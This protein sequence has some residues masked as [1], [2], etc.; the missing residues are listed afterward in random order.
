MRDDLDHEIGEYV[1]A[2]IGVDEAA[3]RAVVSRILRSGLGMDAV[4]DRLI[5]AALEL[6]GAR[7][8]SGEISVAQEHVATEI[9]DRIVS[10][11]AA[12]AETPHKPVGTALVACAEGEWHSLAARA[13]H[14]C[15]LSAG[16]SARL[17]GPSVS[18]S[19]LAAAIYDEGPDIVAISCSL[20]AN[21]PGARKMTIAS[22]ET[23]TPVVVGGR[24]L[25]RDAELAKRLG[26]AAWSPTASGAVSAAIDTLERRP[27]ESPT[28]P[29][30]DGGLGLIE[31]RQ[32]EILAKLSAALNV[33]DPANDEMVSGGVWLL[34]TL[35]ASVMCDDLSILV[36]QL[37]WQERRAR[38]G[39]AL[40]AADI[41]TALAEALP[42]EAP[43]VRTWLERAMAQAETTLDS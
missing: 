5:P 40:P 10:G 37:E 15:F 7:W 19:Q 30:V 24:A 28:T 6:I 33:D 32:P 43:T 1:D 11:F 27:N 9:S 8:E 34:R 18:S 38:L 17:L 25:G 36:S 31:A 13:V 20:P 22:F 16:W 29:I 14:V 12:E 21:L 26:A 23:G 35:A 4:V 41:A 39:R 2:L 3:A 42:A